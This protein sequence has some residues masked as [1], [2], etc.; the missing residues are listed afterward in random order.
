MRIGILS[1]INNSLY[2]R[3]LAWECIQEPGI[4]VVKVVVRKTLSLNRI[5]GEIKRDGARL[6]K[7]VY[8]KLVLGEETIQRGDSKSLFAR[9]KFLN[10][11]GK[12]LTELC[13]EKSIPLLKVGDHNDPWVVEAIREA[14]LDAVLFTG[15]GLIRKNLLE[16]SRLGVI[17][18]HAGLLP[19]YRGMDVVEW[20]ILNS[21]KGIKDIGLTLHI[22]DRGVDTG[23]IL[24]KKAIEVQKGESFEDIRMH[25][26][27]QVVDLM[28]E[29]L[30][31]LRDGKLEAHSQKKEDGRQYFVMHPRVKEA[32]EKNLNSKT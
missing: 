17:N 16:A 29:G 31:G 18:C 22:M 32:A 9:A 13:A 1:P 12:N 2:S 30:R 23:P 26:G 21:K 7:K 11:P 28:M 15:G 27:P 8:K 5:R 6:L 14:K 25:M 3:V 4:D 20:P 19:N 24:I 10:L